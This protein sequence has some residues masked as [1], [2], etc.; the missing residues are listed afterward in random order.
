MRAKVSMN[1]RVNSKIKAAAK[2]LGKRERRSVTNLVES[3]IAE[4]CEKYGIPTDK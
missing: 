4:K 2:E 1:I 3:L